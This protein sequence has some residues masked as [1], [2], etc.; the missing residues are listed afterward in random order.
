M[1]TLEQLNF[2]NSF[3]RFPEIFFSEHKPKALFDDFVNHFNSTIAELPGIDEAEGKCADFLDIFTLKK[4]FA[5]FSANVH[6]K[7]K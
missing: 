4:S 6:S 3:T 2:D 5:G 1:S 7:S